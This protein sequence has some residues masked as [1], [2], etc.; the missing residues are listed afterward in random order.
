MSAESLPVAP[1]SGPEGRLVAS[2]RARKAT[3]WSMELMQSL[4]PSCRRA[5]SRYYS[6]TLPLLSGWD[7]TKATEAT[8]A[9]C[10]LPLVAFVAVQPSLIR[11]LA[12]LRVHRLPIRVFSET[13]LPVYTILGNRASGD[14]DSWKPSLAPI[15]MAQ[16]RT[17]VPLSHFVFV[18][19]KSY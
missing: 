11:E 14:V 15:L 1:S 7:A 19:V 8:K 16:D 12:L 2:S 13:G 6:Y 5:R 10:L 9:L 4:S 18:I 3:A 17:A